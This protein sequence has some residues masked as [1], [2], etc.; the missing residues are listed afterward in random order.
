MQLSLDSETK[1]LLFYEDFMQNSTQ[2]NQLLVNKKKNTRIL[3]YRDQSVS[4]LYG[5]SRKFP[6]FQ[7]SPPLRRP[8][9]ARQML[10][11]SNEFV[12]KCVAKT[13]LP[14]LA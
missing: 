4:G 13:A 14:Y 6:N 11:S 12:S 9:G 5:L 1:E 8:S 7:Y 10:L 2:T 3:H